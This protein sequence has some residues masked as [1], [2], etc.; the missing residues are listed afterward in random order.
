MRQLGALGLVAMALAGLGNQP[1]A[2]E[3]RMN[4]TCRGDAHV[5]CELTNK[6]LPDLARAPMRLVPLRRNDHRLDLI[7]QLIGIAHRTARPVR[8][9][10]QS[11]LPVAIEDLVAGLARYAEVPAHLAHPFALQQSGDKT[12]TFLHDRSLSPRHQHLPPKAKSVTHVSGTKRHLYLRS[13]NLWCVCSFWAFLI[14]FISV[15]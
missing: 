12:K 11:L 7:R 15:V 5:A 1:M 4:S 2:I 10:F 13:D 6:E 9:R 14:F 3:N 8:Q